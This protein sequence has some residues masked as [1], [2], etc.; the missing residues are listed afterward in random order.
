MS[1]EGI[2]TFPH[3]RQL[4]ISN[5]ASIN[6]PKDDK[7]LENLLQRQRPDRFGLQQFRRRH[8]LSV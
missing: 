8:K 3:C 1:L 6:V 2:V 4:R 5:Q 7:V